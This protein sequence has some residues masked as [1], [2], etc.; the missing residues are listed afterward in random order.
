MSYSRITFELNY[1]ELPNFTTMVSHNWYKMQECAVHS[2]DKKGDWP[3]ASLRQCYIG[4]LFF[5]IFPITSA[6]P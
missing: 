5:D 4:S 3:N 1:A 6:C 2:G